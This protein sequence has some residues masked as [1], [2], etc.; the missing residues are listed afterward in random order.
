[1]KEHDPEERPQE[2][3][4]REV[5]CSRQLARA[6]TRRALGF[7]RHGAGFERQ[8]HLMKRVGCQNSVRV[9]TVPDL[10]AERRF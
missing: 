3:W 4:L 2:L 9:A 8:R 7:D 10:Q 6:R 1:M 5:L